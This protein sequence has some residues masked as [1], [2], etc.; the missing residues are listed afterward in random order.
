MVNS[1]LLGLASNSVCCSKYAHSYAINGKLPYKWE[2]NPIFPRWNSVLSKTCHT[3]MPR[4]YDHMLMLSIHRPHSDSPRLENQC[5][6]IT[7]KGSKWPIQTEPHRIRPRKD[8]PCPGKPGYNHDSLCRHSLLPR[9]EAKPSYPFQHFT[10]H[11][12]TH[13]HLGKLEY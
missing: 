10:E 5:L 12:P 3:G 11:I 8:A 9:I 4:L 6:Q 13:H 7:W 2:S 1:D